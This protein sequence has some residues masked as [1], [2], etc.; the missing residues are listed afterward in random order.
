MIFRL[1]AILLIGASVARGF[2]QEQEA[3]PNFVIINID[4]LGYA[5]IEPFGSKLNR[6]PNLN[7]MAAEGMKLTC[8]YAAPVCTPS[9]AALLTGCYPKRALPIPHVLFPENAEGLDPSEVTIAE[10]LKEQGYATAIIG[11]WHLGD[12]PQFLPTRQG[13]DYFYGLPYSNDM[14]PVADGVK[15]NYGAPI[16]KRK[17]KGKGQPPLP[18]MRNET[19]LQRV[20]AEDQAELVANDTSEAIKFI[21]E[22]QKTP[23]FLYLPHS[24]VH[25]PLY[26]GAAFR[27]KSPHGLYSD[28]V[29]EVDWSVGQVLQAIKDCGLDQQTLV[30][31]TSDN[32]GQPRF[33]AVNK[34][35]RAGKGTT[36]EGGM[37]VPTIVRWPGKVPA[38][39]GSDAMVGMMD[40]LPTLVRY[41]GAATPNDRQIDGADIGPI[42]EGAA[43]AQ[44]PHDY[45]YFYR[46]YELEAI[47]R[48]DWKLRLK[49]GKLY[50]LK[51]DISETRDVADENAEVVGQLQK[52]A[53]AMDADLGIKK[54]GPGCRK[55]GIEKNPE[56]LIGFDGTVRAGF[57]PN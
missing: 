33:G 25:F 22:H 49:D 37:R 39:T 16:P 42:L 50:N 29:E 14:G 3:R 34:P 55:V 10:L 51:E 23:F 36:Y 17:R 15:S 7:K 48:G 1:L 31:F 19:V 52:A 24:A 44:S 54:L 28:W 32:G 5:D 4:D 53:A 27:G 18:L 2:A 20:L 30:I 21:R 13:F 43:G 12:Q 56:P 40:L 26:P 11:K 57:A 41:A 47:R 8:F 35:L 9:R 46:G 38:D 6:T 45:F